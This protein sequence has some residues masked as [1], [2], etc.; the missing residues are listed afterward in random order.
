MPGRWAGLSLALRRWAR[1]GAVQ[2]ITDLLQRSETIVHTHT[3][4]H[5]DFQERGR[6]IGGTRS[7]PAEATVCYHFADLY[8]LLAEKI[9]YVYV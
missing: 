4:H 2:V 9:R 5:T 1:W 7:M 3:D 6:R 8:G